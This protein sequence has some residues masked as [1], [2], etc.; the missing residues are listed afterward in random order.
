MVKAKVSDFLFDF[1]LPDF[2][3][4]SAKKKPL[5]VELFNDGSFEVKIPDSLYNFL[6]DNLP[7]YSEKEKTHGFEKKNDLL[8][9]HFLREHYFTELENKFSSMTQDALFLKELESM[10][11]N[12]KVIFI[13]SGYKKSATLDDWNHAEIGN[14][15]NLN[16]HFFVCYEIIKP[17]NRPN[18]EAPAKYF[19]LSRWNNPYTHIGNYR[20]S[21]PLIRQ[22][23]DGYTKIKWT[24]EREDFLKAVADRID[25]IS[26]NIDEFVKHINEENFA[27]LL[28]KY[29]SKVLQIENKGD[30]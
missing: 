10:D 7:D 20:N 4:M 12:N 21:L 2:D 19:G 17:S 11:F 6:K 9:K 22:S 28:E 25:V 16:F 27:G 24:Q 3:S 23:F 5:K 14:K 26:S 29:K 15:H 8:F 30:S 13:K 18:W 1:S